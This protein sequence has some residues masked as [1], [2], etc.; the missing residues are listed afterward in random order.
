L[1]PD[2][3]VEG[4]FKPEAPMKRQQQEREEYVR[5]RKEK[6]AQAKDAVASTTVEKY[7]EMFNDEAEQEAVVLAQVDVEDLAEHNA[8]ITQQIAEKKTQEADAFQTQRGDVRHQQ[9]ESA[10]YLYHKGEVL[11]M[12]LQRQEQESIRQ[13]ESASRR[14]DGAFGQSQSI[15]SSYLTDSIAKSQGTY[16]ELAVR[17]K[18][19]RHVLDPQQDDSGHVGMWRV[20]P[21]L[22][23][24]HVA[25]LRCVK[26]KLPKGRYAILCT[27]VDRLG[28]LPLSQQKKGL[29]RTRR[30]TA[31]KPHSGEYHLNNLIFNEAMLITV[32]P[33]SAIRPAMAL[34]FELFLL[35]SKE[36]AQDQVLGWGAFPLV[37]SDFELNKGLFKVSYC[38]PLPR[39]P[40]SSGLSTRT[41]ANTRTSKI[42]TPTTWTRGWRTCTSG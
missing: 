39:F 5:Q 21:Q 31:P 18:S 30:V 9:R 1:V 26:D 2:V 16:R 12:Q 41:S 34:L 25:M 27:I 24:L 35:K 15:L 22:I 6:I 7:A 3:K 10:D 19:Q 32:P 13:I 33:R 11:R 8:R 14:V 37:D 20:S 40:C 28:G 23:E 29:R 4:S 42:P 17:E 38:S 36:F